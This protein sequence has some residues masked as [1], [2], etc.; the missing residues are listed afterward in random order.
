MDTPSPE[1]GADISWESAFTGKRHFGTFVKV[2]V[3]D[4]VR[5]Y[6]VRTRIGRVTLDL[7][8]GRVT[9]EVG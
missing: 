6:R 1:P 2:V 9:R 7:L 8:P 3:V 4:G 5:K